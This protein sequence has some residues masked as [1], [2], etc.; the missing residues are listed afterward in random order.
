M[1]ED[2]RDMEQR[3]AKMETETELGKQ[4]RFNLHRQYESL[5]GK[6]DALLKKIDGFL[7]NCSVHKTS[8][9]L[10]RQEVSALQSDLVEL[11]EDVKWALRLAITSLL[12]VCGSLVYYILT[13]AK[14]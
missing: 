3:L 10:L 8:T 12:G 5:E 14:G 13:N 11:A 6:L 7:D 2:S 9:A 4:S 1:S